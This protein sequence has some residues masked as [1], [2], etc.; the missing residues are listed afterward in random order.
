MRVP[1]EPNPAISL[2]IEALREVGIDTTSVGYLD[3]RLARAFATHDILHVDW[4]DGFVRTTRPPKE[5]AFAQAA[6]A[7]ALLGAIL[8]RRPVFWSLHNA[9]PHSGGGRA[10]RVWKGIMTRLATDTVVL[11]PVAADHAREIGLKGSLIESSFGSLLAVH[12]RVPRDIAR[13]RWAPAGASAVLVHFGQIREQKGVIDVLAAMRE[14]E[15][16]DVHLIIAGPVA[17]PRLSELLAAGATSDPRVTVV[18]RF[19]GDDELGSLLSAA[20]VALMPYHASLTTS[21]AHLAA[22]L[23]VAIVAPDVELFRPYGSRYLYPPEHGTPGL[24]AAT[25]HAVVDA[26]SGQLEIPSF[27]APDWADVVEPVARAYRRAVDRPL[28]RRFG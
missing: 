10:W 20:N 5:R 25:R 24:I 26:R 8:R 15:D 14:I 11:S 16:D 28:W 27:V 3:R 18:P 9:E 17:S 7:A 2:A 19:L 23:G 12:P 1:H 4:L 21:S 22:E 13:V 6:L